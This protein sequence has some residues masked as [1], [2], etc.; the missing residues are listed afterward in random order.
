MRYHRSFS[1]RRRGFTMIELLVVLGIISVLMG[2]LLPAVQSARESA[3]RLDCQARLAS[4]GKSMNSYMSAYNHYPYVAHHRGPSAAAWPTIV[5]PSEFRNYGPF[6]NL[7][8]FLEEQVVFASFNF[9]V[10]PAAPHLPA[11]ENRTA[12]GSHL[13][14]FLCPTDSNM[15]S[16]QILSWGA[17]NYRYSLGPTYFHEPRNGSISR[18]NERLRRG[19]F[20]PNKAL[21]TSNFTDGLSRTAFVSEKLR[22]G[23]DS[24][25]NAHADFWYS[26]A[27]PQTPQELIDACSSLR[28][29]P[30]GFSRWAGGSWLMPGQRFSAY[31]HDLPPNSTVPDC[32]TSWNNQENGDA[33]CITARSF[34]PGGIN[35]LFGDGHVEWVADGIDP[36][37]WRAVGT[38]NGG[39]TTDWRVR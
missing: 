29:E 33:G 24:T 3:R 21:R 17:T 37:V 26:D 12:A 13:R 1:S 25:F 5:H 18:P 8:P 38:R 2:L 11:L 28:G 15:F 35:V 22:S 9:D 39:E 19:A 6:L 23:N 20:T 4:I 14:A 7:L 36:E 34:H 30:K 10:P 32:S 27:L 31:N 16:G